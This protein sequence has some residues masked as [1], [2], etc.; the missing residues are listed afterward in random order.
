M[1]WAAIYAEHQSRT[2]EQ[3]RQHA[4]RLVLRK[5]GNMSIVRQRP[6]NRLRLRPLGTATGQDY[7]D[8]MCA[9]K[10]GEHDHPV[11]RNPALH[12]RTRP[13]ME[14]EWRPMQYE[15]MLL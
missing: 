7:G 10:L 2:L 6:R 15:S 8:I 3:R 13:W 4:D 14:H 12:R 1:Q 9:C 11:A 5:H